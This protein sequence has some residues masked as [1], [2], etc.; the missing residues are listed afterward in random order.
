MR[1]SAQRAP[2]PRP[3][4]DDEIEIIGIEEGKPTS[5]YIPIGL[6]TDRGTVE[7]RYYA[8]EG[9]ARAAIWVGGAG[10]GWD[11]PH[12][13]YPRL[14]QELKSHGI[15]S[16][17][18]RYRH[19]AVLNESILDALAGASFLE[20]EGVKALALTGW[21]FG[22]AVAIGAGANLSSART[23][24][25]VATQSYGA[26]TVSGLPRDCSLLLLHGTGDKTLS[27]ACSRFVFDMAHEPKELLLFEGVNHGLD[28]A[29]GRVYPIVRDWIVRELG[30]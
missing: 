8:V 3:D 21:S 25:T 19:A 16:L 1:F 22:G 20:G 26:D 6:A 5:G 12:N 27:P 18:V 11:S 24:V 2:K 23:V 10:G 29:A 14:C 9:A 15:A 13:L 17:R 28:Q 30:A 7:C 4:R